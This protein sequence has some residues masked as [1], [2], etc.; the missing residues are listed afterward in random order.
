MQKPRRRT[1]T[2]VIA[3]ITVALLADHGGSVV[4]E[5]AASVRQ[6]RIDV[7]EPLAEE[8]VESARIELLE[9]LHRLLEHLGDRASAPVRSPDGFDLLR[10]VEGRIGSTFGPRIHP[11]LGTLRKHHGVDL[12]AP[13]GTPVLAAGPGRVV[14]A[15]DAGGYGLLVTLDHGGSLETRYAH[16]SAIDVAAGDPILRGQVLGRVGSTGLSTGPHL[17][18]ELRI[19]GEPVNPAPWIG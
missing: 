18:F 5:N 12:S 11:I 4:V 8:L 9:D 16:L 1:L 3:G 2:A 19:G 6:R 10:P 14:R 17:H 7:F 15:G 13:E